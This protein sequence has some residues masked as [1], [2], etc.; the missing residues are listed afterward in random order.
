MDK[1][2]LGQKSILTSL[3][4]FSI[5]FDILKLK[6]ALSCIFY[7]FSRWILSRRC[8]HI[9]WQP[10]FLNGLH[11][12]GK[13]VFI[14]RW[15][16][17]WGRFHFWGHRH[18]W[19]RLHLEIFCLSEVVFTHVYTPT[20][21]FPLGLKHY[22]APRPLNIGKIYLLLTWG[23]QF[24]LLSKAIRIGWCL[25]PRTAGQDFQTICPKRLNLWSCC[26]S[27]ISRH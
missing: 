26:T 16:S 11:F 2:Y 9:W 22:F 14:V 12:W 23:W 13:V 1:D 17:F 8:L 15:S 5:S 4:S 27:H 25:D 21:Y 3:P 20:Q 10:K 19:S 18:F 6:F 24:K 7:W